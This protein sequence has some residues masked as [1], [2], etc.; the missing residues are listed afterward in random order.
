[1]DKEVPKF[2]ICFQ[3]LEDNDRDEICEICNKHKIFSHNQ[4]KGFDGCLQDIVYCVLETINNADYKDIIIGGALW[5]LMKFISKVSYSGFITLIIN[6]KKRRYFKGELLI[7]DLGNLISKIICNSNTLYGIA[8]KCVTQYNKE[9]NENLSLNLNSL[10]DEKYLQIDIENNTIYMNRRIFIYLASYFFGSSKLSHL[11]K[12]TWDMILLDY[13]NEAEVLYSKFIT[14]WENQKERVKY[15]LNINPQWLTHQIYLT[16]LHELGHHRYKIAPCEF[17][18]NRMFV[19]IALMEIIENI[20]TLYDVESE[21]THLS[22]L[23]DD[24]NEKT[25]VINFL[26][27]YYQSCHYFIRR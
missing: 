9:F 12:L 20:E 5:D 17:E 27:S 25:T 1:M 24:S 2:Q 13:I 16:L 18:E 4:T 14:E 10:F 23:L 19:R 3:S 11:Y 22:D 26:G 8:E 7:K 6:N 15:F 21:L